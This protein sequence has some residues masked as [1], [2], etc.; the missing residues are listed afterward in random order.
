MLTIKTIEKSITEAILSNET[1]EEKKE[2]IKLELQRLNLDNFDWSKYC[3]FLDGTYTRNAV[4][5]N[6]NFSILI[7]CWARGCKSPIH[8]HPCD[9]CFI[10]GCKG[11]LSETKFEKRP[12]S[13]ELT[14]YEKSSVKKGDIAWMHDSLGFHQII[15]TSDTEDAITL[16]V[17]H[18]PFNVCKGYTVKGD[19]WNCAPKFYSINGEKLDSTNI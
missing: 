19:N 3:Y 5:H 4:V 15:N 1:V 7:L 9:G 16:H 6:E 2:A 18:P 12:D 17:Y 8:D 13:E 14:S 11:E 10:V